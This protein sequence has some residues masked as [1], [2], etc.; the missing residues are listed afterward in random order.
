MHGVTDL[1]L[2]P[3]WGFD[4][5][6][7]QPILDRLADRLAGRA[8]RPLTCGWSLGAL[9]A[10]KSAATTPLVLVGATPRF[11]QAPDWPDAQPPE[12]LQSF[13][14]DVAADARGALS[15]FAAL[16]NQGD[17]QARA[18]T[19]QM[20]AMLAEPDTA[21][22]LAGLAELRD[23]DLRSSLAA[24]RQP[25]LIVHGERDSLMP[26]AAARWLAAHLPDA[27]LEIFAGC[28]HAPFLSEPD[29]FAA[30]LQEFADA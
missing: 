28:A 3:G 29:R 8:M 4:Q 25:V 26:T 16:I 19:R 5:R 14:A 13:A 15:R 30:L 2:L 18:L 27:R 7:F 22:L 17:A 10:L 23:T 1:A 24:I 12:L 11:L 20:T 6:V 9:R 21:A